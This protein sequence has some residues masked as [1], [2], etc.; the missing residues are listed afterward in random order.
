MKISNKKTS[1]KNGRSNSGAAV[2]L[3][4]IMALAML[5]VVIVIAFNSTV[6][7]SARSKNYSAAEAASLTAATEISRIVIED[8]YYGYI[9]LADY[10]PIGR[11]T[12]APDGEPL[13]VHGINTVTAG[14]RLLDILACQTGNEEMLV[15]AQKEAVEARRAAQQLEKALRAALDPKSIQIFKDLDGN[16]VKPF[17]RAREVLET[18][19]GGAA[20]SLSIDDL[21]LQLGWIKGGSSTIT[22]VPAGSPAVAELK[23]SNQING[24]YK[25]FVDLPVGKDSYFLAGLAE[26]PSLVVARNFMPADN[27]RVSSAVLVSVKTSMQVPS[28][29]QHKNSSQEKGDSFVS[30]ACAI[31]GALPVVYPSGSMLL[32][33]PHGIPAGY[34]RFRDL[35]TDSRLATRRVEVLTAVGDFPREPGSNVV[36]SSDP[37]DKCSL[38]GLFSRGLFQW[39]RACGARPRIESILSALDHEFDAKCENSKRGRPAVL[40]YECTASG[41]IAVRELGEDTPFA[42]QVVHDG[43]SYALAPEALRANDADWSVS[44]RSQVDDLS[45]RSGG[46][47]GGQMMPGNPVNW[48]DLPQFAGG[49][50]VAKRSGKG[51]EAL[52]LTVSGAPLAGT[53]G[54]VALNGSYFRKT[55]GSELATQPRK[56][57][58][59]GG[60]AVEF[61]ISS[62]VDPENEPG[63]PRR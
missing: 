45:L 32:Q 27:K 4:T 44:F 25:S 23:N 31:P 28:D 63:S 38:R 51:T 22:R 37:L 33:F 59:S 43:Q 12:R 3:L 8:P 1:N 52:R 53:E 60:L 61:Q 6:W 39:I 46:N 9:S 57:I 29:K 19:L 7:F 30:Q 17:A 56:S 2:L 47:H 13:P 15:L 50:D 35:L 55:N 49:A 11:A 41:D 26:Q 14:A 40:L 10:A 20:A 48:C 36:S 18:A 16:Q 21:Q 5:A 42:S 62:P 54:G 58:Y 24:C 34:R